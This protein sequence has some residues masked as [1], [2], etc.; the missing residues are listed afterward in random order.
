MAERW[1]MCY[2]PSLTL[3]VHS[4]VTKS[5]NDTSKDVI[6]KRQMLV[7][8]FVMQVS[9]LP[10]LYQSDEFVTLRASNNDFERA[11]SFLSKPNLHSIAERYAIKF[12]DFAT[13]IDPAELRLS[14][15]KHVADL[16]SLK[17]AMMTMK[18]SVKATYGY[19]DLM[20]VRVHD[21]LEA[22]RTYHENYSGSVAPLRKSSWQ[23][24]NPFETFHLVCLNAICDIEAMLAA[25][26][27]VEEWTKLLANKEAGLKKKKQKRVEVGDGKV[28]WIMR[29][30]GRSSLK[31]VAKLEAEIEQDTR[32]TLA[33]S[34]MLNT[35]LRHLVQADLPNFLQRSY[36]AMKCAFK[37]LSSGIYEGF[38][39]AKQIGTQFDDDIVK[40]EVITDQKEGAPH[41]PEVEEGEEA[42]KIEERTD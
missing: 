28:T 15:K 20:K 2:V 24:D 33:L 39:D 23:E 26:A 6:A 41:A 12:S 11:V 1:P 8:E 22:I 17:K 37:I 10:H 21:L 31:V 18:N 5:A 30:F 40:A 13:G 36:T 32:D 27:K 25:C 38:T 29:L 19:Y 3:Q 4:G 7:Q 42:A 16:E 9:E 34:S 35:G 14:L